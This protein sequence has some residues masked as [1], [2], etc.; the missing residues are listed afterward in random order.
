MSSKL[1]DDPEYVLGWLEHQISSDTWCP[2]SKTV[3]NFQMSMTDEER[4]A[5]FQDLIGKGYLRDLAQEVPGVI[6][7]NADIQM[8][9]LTDSR[10]W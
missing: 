7:S 5:V 2:M 1:S 6:D 4:S 10:P 9:R 3:I 8:Y